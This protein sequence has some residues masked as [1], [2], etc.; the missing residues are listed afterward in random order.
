MRILKPKI[1]QNII[2]IPG[3]KT[4]RKIV[5]IESD[6][7]GSIRMPSREV[8]DQLQKEGLEP[9]KDPYLKYDSLASEEDLSALF[10]SLFSVK[11][12]NGNPAAITA[13]CVVANPD[14]DKIK[15][16]NFENYFYEPFTKTLKRYPKHTNSVQLWE[17][18]MENKIFRPQLHGREHINVYNWMAALRNND[19]MLHKA[20]DYQMISISSMP[21]RLELA[22]MESLDYFSDE[23]AS[24]KKQILKEGLEIFERLFKIKSESFIAN[25]YIW[26]NE[27]EQTL[28]TNG[29]NFIQGIP[30][31]YQ[32]AHR[33][34]KNRYKKKYHYTG[35][36]NRFG[37][38]YLVR[39]AH[40]EPS[41]VPGK[42]SVDECLR[43]VNIAFRWGKPA[44][45]STHRLNFIGYIHPENRKQNLKEFRELL[46]QI[47][48]NWPETEFMTS[49]QLG[50][51]ILKNYK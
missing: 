35:Q 28:Q 10:D 42:N 15:A 38:T 8:Y 51:L 25:C 49:D 21:S 33:N 37:Q 14:F 19:E 26:D 30:I 4:N 5:V 12:K 1:L 18:G 47:V 46:R 22:Y 34:N 17:E 40:F 48:K 29:V 13:N 16:N 24:Q 31:Q 39:N 45:I 50:N 3:W 2:S 27:L 44:I 36:K 11:D 7:W 43:R 20:F 32:P 6:D 23:E 9:G 41:Q